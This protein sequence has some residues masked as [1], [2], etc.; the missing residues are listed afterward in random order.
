MEHRHEIIDFPENS[1]IK[2]FIHKIGDVNLHWHQSIEL[3]YIVSGNVKITLSGDEYELT[4]DGLILINSNVP[5]SLYSDNATMIAAQIRLDLLAFVPDSVRNCTFDCINDKGDG[6]NEAFFPIK[7]CLA[8]LLKLNV[9]GGKQINIMNVSLCYKLIYELYANFAR[10]SSSPVSASEEQLKRLNVLLSYINANYYEDLSLDGLASVV[11]VTVPY[12]S[13]TFKQNIGMTVGEYVKTIRLYHASTMLSATR[14][15]IEIICAKC[16]F[17]NTH[18]FISAFKSKYGVLPSK[19]RKVNKNTSI[20][21]SSENAIGYYPTNTA[22]LYSAVSDFIKNYADTSMSVIPRNDSANKVGISVSPTPLSAIKNLPIDIIGVSRAKELLYSS[23]REQLRDVQKNIGFKFIKVHSIFDDDMMVY[24]EYDGVP[25]YNFNLVDDIYDFL[26]SVN[27]KPYVQLSFMP[28]ALARYPDKKTFYAG[29]ITSPPDDINKWN[30]LVENFVTHL[31]SRYGKAEVESWVFAVWNEPFTSVKLFGYADKYDYYELFANSYKTIKN[32]D[33][34]VAVG[35]PSH[36]AAHG[37]SDVNLYDFMAWARANSCTPDFIDLHYY[38]T[39]M[40]SPIYDK[41][42][43]KISTQLSPRAGTF[44][45][46]IEDIKSRLRGDG[47]GGVPVYLTE[48]NSTTSHRDLLSDTCFKSAY[49]VKNLI[50]NIGNLDM[51]GYWLLSDFHEESLMNDKLFHGGLG[52]FTANGIKKPAYFAYSFLSK[53]GKQIVAQGEGYIATK[54]D[55]GFVILLVNYFHYSKAYAEEVGINTTY[56]D[57]YSV[58]PESSKKQFL[59]TLPE[60]RGRYLAVHRYVNR[61]HGSA[62][63]NFIGMGAVE[64]LSAD[65]TQWLKSMT[66][67]QIKKEI[68]LSPLSVS[69][70]LS[71]FEIR[72]IEITPLD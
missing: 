63:D 32:I 62:F 52:L 71:P 42:G 14:D 43:I 48:W 26:L 34:N 59:F 64:P 36:F 60:T 41:N 38:D 50:D 29:V 19:W 56:K 12:L 37:K 30:A 40:T 5:H 65:E 72:L 67:P 2:I 51:F 27:L 46:A 45:S 47:F 16:G 68:L 24:S 69:A 35:G 21:H 31:I 9:E 1:P 6:G 10:D 49:I 3:L 11:N 44:K 25:H 4:D 28:S 70:I 33:A 66:E 20:M 55:D 53:L 18:S 39:D 61:K 23:I 8:S 15:S 54:K 17:P 58:F 22:I 7:Q 57:R 13:K